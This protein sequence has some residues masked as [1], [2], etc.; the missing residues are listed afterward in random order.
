MASSK[1]CSSTS[2]GRAPSAWRKPNFARAL[3][4]RDQHDVHNADAAHQQRDARHP[5]EQVAE[6]FRSRFLRGDDILLG[7]DQ[8]IGLA[9]VDIVAFGE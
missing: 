4:D 3:G 7:L 2:A 9:G 8:E 1:N 6:C 5:G